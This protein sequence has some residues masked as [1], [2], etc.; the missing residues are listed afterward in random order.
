MLTMSQP[1][2]M[3]FVPGY[4]DRYCLHPR[5]LRHP[6]SGET[7]GQYRFCRSQHT[8]LIPHHSDQENDMNM[9]LLL[10]RWA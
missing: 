1:W 10:H 3:V 6:A 5:E 7:P 9:V 8:P 2:P 4:E